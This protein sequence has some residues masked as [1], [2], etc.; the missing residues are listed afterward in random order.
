MLNFMQQKWMRI[1]FREERRWKMALAYTLA[2]AVMEWHAAGSLEERVKRGICVLWSPTYVKSEAVQDDDMQDGQQVQ[3]EATISRES[4]PAGRTASTLLGVDYGSDE[5]EEDQQD[6]VDALQ[7]R[8]MLD[9]ALE[10]PLQEETHGGQESLIKPKTEETDD[11]SAL[12]FTNDNQQTDTQRDSQAVDQP[13]ADPEEKDTKV[14]ITGL[15][16]SSNNPILGVKTS[17]NSSSNNGDSDTP[18]ASTKSSMKQVYAPLRERILESDLD[19][20]FLDLD[21]FHITQPRDSSDSNHDPIDLNLPPADLSTIFPELQ[22]LGLLDVAP[23]TGP[24]PE[25]KKKAEKRSDRDDPNKRIEDTTY[26]KL[27]P[28]GQFMYTK[29]TLIGPL[30]P[31]KNW[32]NGKWLPL[33]EPPI[34]VE[35]EGPTRPPEDAMSGMYQRLYVNWTC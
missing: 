26:T 20:L 29:P 6:V 21:D 16:S 19:K 18:A 13:M 22:P 34:Y 12:Q 7:P 25:G 24:V 17:S 14:G 5:E 3:P 11:T 32:K 10:T 33:D 4:E 35:Y 8:T 9:D 15:K 31:S 2:T 23:P 27:V 30:Q 1:D 28:I